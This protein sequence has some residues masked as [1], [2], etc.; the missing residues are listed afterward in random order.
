MEVK[1]GIADVKAAIGN[2][3]R[4]KAVVERSDLLLARFLCF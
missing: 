4:A 2:V 1:G 3:D